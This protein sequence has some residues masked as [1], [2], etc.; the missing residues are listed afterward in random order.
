[1]N[2]F[3]II[4]LQNILYK[5]LNKEELNALEYETIEPT[6]NR[7]HLPNWFCEIL[8][9]PRW[10]ANVIQDMLVDSGFDFFTKSEW[11][12]HSPDL[13]PAENIGN[14]L[15]D[16][17]DSLMS[18]AEDENWMNLGILSSHVHNVLKDLESETELFENLLLSMERCL[19]AVKQARESHTEYW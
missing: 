17:V 12:S 1:M 3:K 10:K 4:E 8:K 18:K 11:P 6:K 19:E 7:I 2:I 5:I 15:K 9:Y 13:N 14:I 16:C